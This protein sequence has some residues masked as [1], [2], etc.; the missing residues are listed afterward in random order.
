MDPL[1]SP[2]GSIKLINTRQSPGFSEQLYIKLFSKLHLSPQT[3]A[4]S[5]I[6]IKTKRINMQNNIKKEA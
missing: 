5:E 4:I 2:K 6:Y 1:M 3:A